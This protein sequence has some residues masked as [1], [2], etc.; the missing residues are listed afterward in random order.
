MCKFIA[1]YVIHWVALIFFYLLLIVH[2][3][4]YCNPSFWKWLLPVAV[5]LI[6]EKL[7]AR[8]IAKKYTVTVTMAA[9]YDESCRVSAIKVDKPTHFCFTPGQYVRVNIPDIGDYTDFFCR[10]TFETLL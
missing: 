3:V 7:Y 1:F 6:A 5:L 8:F 10:T 2:G 9:P 4:N